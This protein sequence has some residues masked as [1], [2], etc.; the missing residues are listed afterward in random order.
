[1]GTWLLRRYDRSTSVVG[2]R[3]LRSERRGVITAAGAGAGQA[4]MLMFGLGV[5]LWLAGYGRVSPGGVI[6]GVALLQTVLESARGLAMNGAFAVRSSF[7][8]RRYLWV[9]GYS[10]GVRQPER[11]TD[12]PERLN[13]GLRL[14]GV[15]FRY[16]FTEREVLHDVSITLRPGSV[17]ALVGDNG[18]GKSTLIK[19]LCRFYDPTAGRITVDDLDLRSLDLDRWRASITAGFQDF[20]RFEFR[21]E[22]S[23]GASRVELLDEVRTD[24]AART[25]SIV[26]AAQAGGADEFLGRLPDGYET[27]LGRQFGGAQLSEGQWQRV[28]MARA[29]LREAPLLMLLD[30]PTAALD[31]RAEHELF[32]RHTELTTAARARGAVTVLV[33]HRYSTVRMADHI[34][35]LEDGR[36]AQ[37]GDHD[38]LVARDGPYRRSFEAQ[39]R[40][41]QDTTQPQS[42]DPEE[43]H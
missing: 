41:Y 36:V 1:M 24:A 6:L 25:A 7:A 19:L 16:P 2:Q 26:R 32:E 10:G 9:L 43:V 39:A 42:A 12:P 8:A 4:L 38:T 33:S 20:A 40:R 15:S 21:A 17:V 14:S 13:A 34:V 29:F 18:A 5:L 3:L 22:E 35:V 30:E 11:P 28:A 37:E 31:P 27:Q 23:I